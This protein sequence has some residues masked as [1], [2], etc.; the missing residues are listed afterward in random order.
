MYLRGWFHKPSRFHRFYQRPSGLRHFE[1]LQGA[2]AR[3]RHSL[4]LSCCG[5]WLVSYL[6]CIVFELASQ[7]ANHERPSRAGTRWVMLDLPDRYAVE[8]V[9][10][11]S[12][13]CLYA[14][15]SLLVRNISRSVR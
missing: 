9:S 12:G 15:C 5:S 4:R 3:P 6:V 7:A 13:P 1:R 11:L 2:E 8:P 10:E 14:G